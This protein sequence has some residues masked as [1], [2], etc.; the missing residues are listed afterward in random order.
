MATILKDPAITPML[1][2]AIR[3]TY[4][5]GQTIL[6]PGDQALRVYV[7]ESGAI[8][9]QDIDDQGNRKI[10]HIFGPSTLFPMTS[11]SQAD[12][13]P[14]AWFYTALVDT[15]VCILP[16]DE[17]KRRLEHVDSISAYTLLLKQSLNEIHE[18]LTRITSSTKSTSETRLI[19]ALKFLATHHVKAKSG[20]WHRVNFPVPQQLLAD[21]TGLTRETVSLTLKGFQQKKLVRYPASGKLEINYVRLYKL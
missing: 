12:Y 2:Q 4:L 8:S 15:E 7:V 17:F 6:Y 19:A 20:S 16:Y 18:L 11:F 3:R 9:M 1:D 5:K 13:A 14:V 21:I 10:L